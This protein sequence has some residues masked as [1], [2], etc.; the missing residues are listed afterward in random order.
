MLIAEGYFYHIRDEFFSFVQDRYLMANKEDDA[1]RPHYL[2]VQDSKNAAIYWMIPVSSKINK[3][4]ALYEH[5][6]K[7]YGT[8]TKIVLGEC[9]GRDAAFLIQNAFPV[10][11]DYFD[12][13]HTVNEAP[14]TLHTSTR[15]P[16]R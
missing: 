15:Q 8:C 4:R 12:H 16:C 6:K 1:Y 13:V 3:F 7:K 10:T 5:Q 11:P 14:V 9:G 2:A